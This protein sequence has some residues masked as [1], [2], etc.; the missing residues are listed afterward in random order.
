VFK[1]ILIKSQKYQF[2]IN[3]E[4]IEENEFMDS[5]IDVVNDWLGKHFWTTSKSYETPVHIIWELECIQ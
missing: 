4:V 3:D 5:M 1:I 2:V